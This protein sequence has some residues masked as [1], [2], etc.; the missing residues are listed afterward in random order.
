[1][2]DAA[3]RPVRRPEEYQA[4]TFKEIESLLQVLKVQRQPVIDRITEMKRVRR[5]QWEQV[6]RVIPKAY[7]QML[8]AADAPQFEDQLRRLAGLVAKH[9]PIF[10]VIPPS[11]RPPDV[12]RAAREEKRLQAT[13]M[14]IADQQDRDPYAM[15]IDAQISAGESW[16]SVW[17]DPKRLNNPEYKRGESEDADEYLERTSKLMADGGVPLVITD[18]DAQTVFPFR[19]DNERLACVL[20]ETEHQPID[21]KLGHG[22]EPIRGDDGKAK[23]WVL[24]GKTLSEPFLASDSRQGLG[25]G[26][27]DP[28]HDRGTSDDSQPA[29]SGP[30]RKIVFLDEWCYQM[31]LDGVLVEQWEHNWGVVP[32]FPGYGSQTS[33]RDPGY[34]SS[35]VLD[36]V[37]GVAKQT[38]LFSAILASNAMQHGFPTP[39]LK[40]PSHGI[41]NPMTGQPIARTIELGKLNFLGPQE[42]LEFP[43]LKATMLPDF[44][45][46]MDYLT[47]QLDEAGIGGLSKALGTDMA[48]YAIAQIRSQQMAVLAPVY[49]NAV[50]QWRK[51]AYFI[52]HIVK[53]D[54]KGGFYL[55]GAVEEAENGA[56]Y[57]PILKFGPEHCTDDTINCHIDE[58]IKQDEIAE[59]KSAIEMKDAGLWS[60]RRAMEHVGVEDADAENREI[61]ADRVLSSPAA[62]EVVLRM[63]TQIATTRYEATRQEQSSPFYQELE[64]AKQTYMG[65]AGQFANQG[66]S[67]V[68]ALPG[69]QPMQQNP[70]VAAPQQGGPQAGPGASEGFPLAD[71]GQQQTPGGVANQVPVGAPG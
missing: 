36:P 45:R 20:I 13:V 35:G 22:Y 34:Q 26:V 7:R 47:G 60:R 49:K 6:L 11:P 3:L 57:R 16:L 61:D 10:E 55:R 8:V 1:M 66:S 58:G 52:R 37:I 9:E 14:Q 28:T 15:G 17:P 68:N 54:F 40:N 69:G 4:P 50:R 51:I 63:A 39:V 48:G 62:D 44:F 32:M 46:Y 53:T 43:F 19:G 2:S 33:D 18:H 65:G 59:R 27:V 67:P 42:D 64:K 31:W 38:V 21:V 29:H 70:A 5:R 12:A 71:L 23:E 41:V 24:K 25:G 30:V 56:Q